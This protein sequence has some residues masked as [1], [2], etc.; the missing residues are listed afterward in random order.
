MKNNMKN[1]K[2]DD[3]SK[4]KEISP[5]KN[6]KFHFEKYKIHIKSS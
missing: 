2:M 5:Y 3:E 4:I 1:K 6:K